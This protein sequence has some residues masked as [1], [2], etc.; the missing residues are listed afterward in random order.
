MAP[1]HWLLVIKECGMKAGVVRCDLAASS[2]TMPFTHKWCTREE[3]IH[4]ARGD[5]PSFGHI[6]S[7]VFMVGSTLR[8]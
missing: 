5:E 1:S 2:S 7:E 4:R 6:Y 3:T 8:N